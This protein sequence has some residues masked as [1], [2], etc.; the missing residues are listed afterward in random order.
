MFNADIA[1][2]NIPRFVLISHR[3]TLNVLLDCFSTDALSVADKHCV[4]VQ[5]KCPDVAAVVS[6]C[7]CVLF[8]CSFINII[9]SDHL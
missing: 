1:V 9:F 5:N 2:F 3:P 6:R 4:S 8:K 7:L